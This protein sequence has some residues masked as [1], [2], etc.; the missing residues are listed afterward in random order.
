M[1]GDTNLIGK[2]GTMNFTM[3]GKRKT[4]VSACENIFSIKYLSRFP[5]NELENLQ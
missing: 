3:L 5:L 4:D 1:F 2:Y